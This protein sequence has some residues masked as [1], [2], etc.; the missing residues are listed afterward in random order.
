[1]FINTLPIIFTYVHLFTPIEAG[2]FL[3]AVFGLVYFYTPVINPLW[4]ERAC[5]NWYVILKSAWLGKVALWRAFWPFF[6]I[7]NGILFYIDYRIANITYTIASWKTVHGMV[8]LPILWW[9]IAVWRCS[10]NTHQRWQAAGA[11]T[12]TIYLFLE[13]LLRLFISIQHP[14]TLFDCRLLVMEYGDCL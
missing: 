1:M 9:T 8:F 6:L 13:L 5:G 10:G 4:K 7:I 2:I 11:R 14:I 12:F 3:T